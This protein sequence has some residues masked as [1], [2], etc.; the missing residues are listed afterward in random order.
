VESWT[1]DGNLA[2]CRNTTIHFLNFE[3]YNRSLSHEGRVLS[4]H[5]PTMVR[6]NTF[7]NW[8]R[9]PSRHPN[10]ICIISV[11]THSFSTYLFLCLSTTDKKVW[12]EKK[13]GRYCLTPVH[14]ECVFTEMIQIMFGWRDGVLYQYRYLFIDHFIDHQSTTNTS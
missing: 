12:E 14:S 10:I 5:L 13:L 4:M 7:R 9:T 1:R 3:I 2:F 8:Y 6:E 11:N